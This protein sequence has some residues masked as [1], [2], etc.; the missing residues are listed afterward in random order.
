[1]QTLVLIEDI[2][3]S[4]GH[5]PEAVRA[6]CRRLGV[7]VRR[8]WADREA[9]TDSDAGKIRSEIE[10]V[11]RESAELHR[12]FERYETDW[13]RRKHEAGEQAFQRFVSEALQQQRAKTPGEGYAFYGGWDQIAVPVGGDTYTTANNVAEEA[14]QEF[15]RREPRLSFEQFEKRWRRRR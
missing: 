1:M 3:G 5:V 7:E 12:D 6:W 13:R 14:R 2:A 15:A 8:D 10:R 11:G 4:V 9:V